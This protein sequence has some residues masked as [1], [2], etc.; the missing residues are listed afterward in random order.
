MD[1]I[2]LADRP[3][4][5]PVVAEWYFG[6][7]GELTGDE[8]A[9]ETRSRLKEYLNRDKLPLLLLA[10]DS[11]SD[12]VLGA[13]QLKYHE[14]DIYPDREHWLGGIIVPPKHQGKGVASVLVRK[15]T[16]IARDLTVDT[17]YL[18]TER[19]DGGLYAKLGWISLEQ[20]TYRRLEVLVMKKIVSG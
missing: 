16:G 3:E 10:V 17:L 9:E 11:G 2:F 15:L 20:V 14:M 8:S 13:G 4:A 7:W 5:I 6:R 12:E 18:Q 19:L 1:F